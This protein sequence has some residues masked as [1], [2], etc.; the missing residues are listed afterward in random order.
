MADQMLRTFVAQEG[1]PTFE[2]QAFAPSPP[3]AEARVAIVTTAGLRKAGD[4]AWGPG[5]QSFRVFNSDDRDVQLGHLSPNF[6]RAGFAADINVVY[7]VDRLAEL[8]ADGTIGSV[9]AHHISFMGAQDDTMTTIRMDSGKA[10]AK[11]FKDDGV[12][13]VILTPV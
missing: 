12:N 13:V 6:D 4:D 7:P 9:G 5:D 8:A 1:V 11:I 2:T 3:L 10:A